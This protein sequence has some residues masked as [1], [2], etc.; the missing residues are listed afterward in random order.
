MGSVPDDEVRRITYANA[1][2][3]FQFTPEIPEGYHFEP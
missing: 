2:K 1:E 3:L